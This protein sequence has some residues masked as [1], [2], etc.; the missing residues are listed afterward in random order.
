MPRVSIIIPCRNEELFIR[1]CLDSLL[2]QTYP[3]RKVEI[4]VVDGQSEDTTRAIVQGYQKNHPFITLINNVKKVIPSGMNNGIKAAKGE[5]IM[6]ID[7]H[8][9]YP[10]DYVSRCVEALDRHNADNV[11]GIIITKPAN[12]TLRA[13][14]IALCLSHWFGVGSSPF[15]KGETAER[16][17]E[18]DTVAFGC[19]PKNVFKKVGLYNEHLIRSS[20]MELNMRVRDKGGKILLIP[21][22]FAY[23]YAS[24]TF[25][26][27]LRHN[28]ADGIWAIYPIKFI[29]RFL[30]PRHLIPFLFIFAILSLAI[31]SFLSPAFFPLLL[32]LLLTYIIVAFIA[33]FEIA[34]REKSI[35]LF[36]LTTVAF[37]IRHVGY[38]VGSF[39]GIAKLIRG[40]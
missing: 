11:G 25:S 36:F 16:P 14:A 5:I 37:L 26:S 28:V 6:K 15:R 2:A 33:S 10:P 18:V 12:R 40:L 21:N 3:S 34:L 17:K 30:L 23:Y 35:S 13:R 39:V 9:T 29:K 22:I 20:D 8:S 1:E 31:T 7:A 32:T 4:I 27:F 38:G 24:A 19:Y